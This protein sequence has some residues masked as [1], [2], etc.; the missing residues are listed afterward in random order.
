MPETKLGHLNSDVTG[1]AVP[2][3]QKSIK[4]STSIK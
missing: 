2:M 4:T 3:P 1:E